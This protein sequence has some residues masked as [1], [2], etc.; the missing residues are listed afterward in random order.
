MVTLY[1]QKAKDRFI[2]RELA[3]LRASKPTPPMVS[4][5]DEVD[6]AAIDEGV[7]RVIEAASHAAAS[8]TVPPLSGPMSSSPLAI[9]GS[10]EPKT[11]TMQD[12]SPSTS[13]APCDPEAPVMQDPSPSTSQ[14]SCYTGTVDQ[15]VK[16]RRRRSV[17]RAPDP[18]CRNCQL[19]SAELMVAKNLLQMR[20]DELRQ[21]HSSTMRATVSVVLFLWCTS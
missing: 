17:L 7:R 11:K 12:P 5:L 4:H 15:Q 1:I 19:L 21:L 9:Q 18:G 16:R 2:G 14:A 8:T 6:D 10:C 3:L 13:N 20:N